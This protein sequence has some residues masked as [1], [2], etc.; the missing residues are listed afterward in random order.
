VTGGKILIVKDGDTLSG[1]AQREYGRWQLWPL[2]YDLNKDKVGPNPN[3]IQPDLGLLTSA[4]TRNLFTAR[5]GRGRKARTY[6]EGLRILKHDL[7]AAHSIP[8]L[9]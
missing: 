1:I 4:S 2:L 5:E 3:R 7:G 6:M 8:T 9:A